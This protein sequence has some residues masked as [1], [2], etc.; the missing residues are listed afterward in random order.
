MEQLEVHDDSFAAYHIPRIPTPS[1]S[2]SSTVS[3][4]RA[5]KGKGK[6]R[7]ASSEVEEE[8]HVATPEECVPYIAHREL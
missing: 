7:A 6:Q 3:S 1:A 5:Q 4:T 8:T 2:S